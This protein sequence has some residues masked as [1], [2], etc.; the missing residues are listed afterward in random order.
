MT[1]R[2]SASVAFG[3][4]SIPEWQ[5]NALKP[6]TPAGDQRPDLPAARRGPRRRKSRNRPE[7]LPCAAWT[8]SASASAVVVTGELFSGMSTSVV[9]PPAAAARVAVRTLPTRYDPVR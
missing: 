2:R 8:F 3:N 7:S 9:I 6:R 1:A 5:R 4:S